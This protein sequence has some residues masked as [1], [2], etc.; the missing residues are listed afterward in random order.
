MERVTT[1][2]TPVISSQPDRFS[3]RRG[4]ENDLCTCKITTTPGNRDEVLAAYR[5]NTNAVRAEHGCIEYSA[6][7]DPLIPEETPNLLGADTFVIVEK[8][9]SF[10]SLQAHRVS[11]H[12]QAYAAKVKHMIAA[13][14]VNVLAPVE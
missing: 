4:N 3:Q 9:D 7:L 2:F 12:M 5:G 1:L 10:E 8:W 14:F 11:P 6:G 13:R